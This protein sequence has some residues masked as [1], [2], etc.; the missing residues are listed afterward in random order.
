MG[1]KYEVD[2][3]M[4]ALSSRPSF[5]CPGEK[6]TQKIYASNLWIVLSKFRFYEMMIRM[7]TIIINNL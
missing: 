6:A 4:A 5:H 3:E 7:K 2:A 1:F